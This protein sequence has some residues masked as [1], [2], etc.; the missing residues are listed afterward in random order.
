MRRLRSLFLRLGG[1][2]DRGRRE[3]EWSA[4]LESHLQLHIEDNL[5]AGMSQE[6]ARR[7]ALLK[8][9]GIESVKESLRDQAS[10]A[11][12]ETTLRDIRYALRSI[13]RSP[14][15]AV[16]TLLSLTLGLGASLAVFTVADNL[17]VR[18]LP[19]FDASRL[20]MVWES[21]PKIGAEHNVVSPANY[22]DW[23]SQNDIFEG[24]AGF[25]TLRS[26]VLTDNGSAQELGAVSV[27]ADFFPLLGVQPVRGRLFTKEEDRSPG[28]VTLISY[29]L[30]Q[31]WFGGDEHIIGRK[32]Q[33][34]SFPFTIIGVLPPNFYFLD[35]E[36]DLWGPL[37]LDPAQDY[38]KTSGR[39]MLSVGRLWPHVKIGQAQAHM[40]ALAK[41]LEQAYPAFNTNWTVDVEPLR[42][43]LFQEAKMPLLVLLA[44]VVMMLAVACANVA[45]LLL[46][47]YSARS[48]EIAVRVS[49][50]AG[51]W[52]VIRQLLTESL[53][54]GAAGGICAVMLAHW[55][56]RSLVV[57]A[58][59]D[60]AKSS[61][62][63]VDL[64]IV[65]CAIALSV[66]TGLLFGLA[67]A[68]VTLRLDLMSALRGDSRAGS[69]GVG[70]RSWL[71]GAE[72]A[73]SVILVAGALLLFRSLVGLET[74]NPGFQPS[75]L[76]TFR[77]TL[78]PAR[79]AT[80][81]L[82]TQ[83]F[84]RAIE[85]L[86]HLPG[87]RAVSAASCVPFSGGCAGTS[88]N[89]E[90]RP[91]AK[92]G[93]E[94]S[95][96][97]QTVMPGYFHTLG[98]PLASGRDFNEFDNSDTA[99]YRFIVNEA[100]AR[101]Y[102][103]GEQPLGKRINVAMEMGNPFGEII[104]VAADARELSLDRE[105][106]PTVYYIHSH[107]SYPRMIFLVRTDAKPMA[108]A[109]PAR[110]VIQRLDPAEPLAAVRTMEDVMGD[111]FARQRFSAWLLAGFAA[112]ALILAGIGI[113][114]ILAYS[115]TARTREF[116]VRAALGADSGRIIALV[117]KSG[118]RP[119]IGGLAIG[120]AG[121]FGLAGLLKSLLFG[122]G[123]HDPAT[124][125]VVPL[126]L[127]AI[128]LVASFLP[129]RRAARLDPME[130]LRTE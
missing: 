118:A 33:M 100:F 32:V 107:L 119:V 64:R 109:E 126:L 11:W 22:L 35:R 123:P 72:V 74:V 117:L 73:M 97:I 114:G 30:W 79:Y 61:G 56:V 101:R 113:Y 36:A 42:D 31:S 16:T 58:P 129:A 89:I 125:G 27:T 96:S 37:G 57:L 39:W 60:L 75:G 105:P 80:P 18:P 115:V 47:R 116:G 2:F 7:E 51:R 45:N 71:V 86:A 87:V 85:Q 38:R 24:M 82:R 92:P 13:A 84:A 52:R 17:L 19:Y 108:L 46:A 95:A 83:F 78:P 67:P 104:G 8:F 70:V 3:R 12:L 77:V 81:R 23:K 99:P 130:A 9:G 68:L 25:S 21:E 106:V 121:A 66:L 53:L 124:F 5:R 40:T 49:L 62:I 28:G 6:E 50:G 88:V 44:A 4:E 29:R 1:W 43:A 128:A 90:G 111:N 10:L 91:P 69:A 54:L 127:A 93:E 59:K 20:V 98:I 48:R 112:I 34:N 76:L 63:H 41:R 65:V 120:V 14:G 26:A 94:I 15:F 102:M 103:R 122:I 110:R 55:A